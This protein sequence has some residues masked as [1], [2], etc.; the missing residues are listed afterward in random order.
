MG[1]VFPKRGYDA[2]R[3]VLAIVLL[4]AAGLKAHQLA[5]E[6]VVGSG[7]LHSR[8]LLIAAVEFELFFGLWLLAGIRPAQ[9]RFAALCCFTLFA[10]VA[11]WKALSG[12]ALCGCFGRVPVN[13]WYTFALDT[14]F[15][16]ALFY[17][18][19]SLGRV[20]AETSVRIR[21]RTAGVVVVWL[22]VGIPATIAMGS[23][24]AMTLVASGELVG[25]GSLVVLEPETWVGKPFPLLRHIDIGQLLAK[26]N[27]IVVLYHHDC[28]KC[29]KAIPKYEQLAC[30]LSSR[31]GG[32]RMA[33]VEIPP[34]GGLGEIAR[35]ASSA[36][37]W[38]RL[39]D[40]RE[41]FVAT[42]VELT[43]ET[44][45]VTNVVGRLVKD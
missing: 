42:P 1:R 36:C 20:P 24:S 26:G 30:E 43:I 23:I 10:G 9:T 25:N 37:L 19:P 35:D 45:S 7:L 33:M 21:I 27:W 29:Q 34:Y 22:A 16:V 17:S 38:G 18:R 14:F 32:V 40:G 3:I 4:A 2:V 41:W 28:S 12:E 39:T 11:L 15:V 31:G 44:G 13:P 5:T 6:P 8:P